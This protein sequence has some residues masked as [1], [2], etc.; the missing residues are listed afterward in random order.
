MDG[1][2]KKRLLSGWVI[3]ALI[4]S[5]PLAMTAAQY[6]FVLKT[7][8]T[9]AEYAE[10]VNQVA[11]DISERVEYEEL[12]PEEQAK[13]DRAINGERL[14]FHTYENVPRMQTPDTGDLLVIKD[15]TYYVFSR[16][17]TF[18]WRTPPGA[19]TVGMLA[20]AVIAFIK[21]FRLQR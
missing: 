4:V 14:Y 5:L 19:A 12:T 13:V 11:P 1:R 7:E 6:E 8:L 20:S 17:R 16:G 3:I 21:L 2:T 15:D 9:Q 10:N 18:A